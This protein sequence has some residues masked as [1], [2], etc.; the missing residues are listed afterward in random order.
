[1][2]PPTQ[3]QQPPA[4]NQEA[5]YSQNYA[6]EIKAMF[7]TE[8]FKQAGLQQRREFVGSAIYKYIDQM[9]GP[10]VAPKITGMIID[11]PPSDLN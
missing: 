11:L 4:M 9:L 6:E 2:P 10:E 3:N 1:M 8:D 7:M 5:A